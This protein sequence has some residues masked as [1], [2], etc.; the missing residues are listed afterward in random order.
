[1]ARDW[2]LSEED[3]TEI[4][5]YSTTFRLFV[6]VQLCAVWLYERFLQAVPDVSPRW[7]N[8]RRVIACKYC[9]KR[10]AKRHHLVR[11]MKWPCAEPITVVVVND[12]VY[13]IW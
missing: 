11:E 4:N 13:K 8:P 2:I 5:K 9:G 7:R 12:E 10:W 6:A 3:G 1:M